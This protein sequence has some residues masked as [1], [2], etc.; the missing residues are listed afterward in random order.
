MPK[1]IGRPILDATDQE[2]RQDWYQTQRDAADRCGDCGHPEGMT[3]ASACQGCGAL[4]EHE[5][6]YIQPGAPG[7]FDTV[8]DYGSFPGRIMFDGETMWRG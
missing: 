7:S 1:R 3:T 8:K 4:W 5:G 6:T 2:E